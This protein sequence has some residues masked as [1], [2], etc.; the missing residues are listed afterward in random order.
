MELTSS[1][2]SEACPTA[3]SRPALS[4]LEAAGIKAL[5]QADDAGGQRPHIAWATGGY[6]IL[7]RPDDAELAREVLTQTAIPIE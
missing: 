5:I 4:V 6:K 7:V 3:S 1:S 2:L